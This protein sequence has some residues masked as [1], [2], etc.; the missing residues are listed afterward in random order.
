MIEQRGIVD[1]LVMFAVLVSAFLMGCLPMWNFD[2][3]MHIRT[4]QLILERQAIPYLDWYSFTDVDRPWI[5]M[6]WLFQ[7]GIA[8]LFELG[9]VRLL[10]LSKAL[11]QMITVVICWR[12][13]GNRLPTWSKAC[14]VLLLVVCLSGR[15]IVRPDM[16][17][18]FLL[19]LYL[20]IFVLAD[21]RPRLLLLLPI[22][23][24]IW[25]NCHGLF[26][27]G[28]VAVAAYCGDRVARY[29]AGDGRFYL[30]KLPVHSRLGW[31]VFAGLATLLAC[32]VNPYFE[33]GATFP[34]VLFSKLGNDPSE[35]HMSALQVFQ[36]TGFKTF[37]VAEMM[38]WC[39]AVVSFIWLASHRRVSL[40][41]L[42]LFIGFSYLAWM[43]ARN[44]AI[45]AIVATV[46]TCQNLSEVLKIREGHAPFI[47][48]RLAKCLPGTVLLITMLLMTSVVT[49][50]WHRFTGRDEFGIGELDDWY[51]HKAAEFAG[52]PGMP[53]RAFIYGYGQAAVFIFHNGPERRVFMDGRLEMYRDETID[54]YFRIVADIDRRHPGFIDPLLDDEGNLPTVIVGN[55]INKRKTLAALLTCP[56]IRLVYADSTAAVFVQVSVADKLQMPVA[57]PE[58]LRVNFQSAPGYF[59]GD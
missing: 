20:L 46:V 11:L 24:V 59:T 14:I 29:L 9:G 16:V 5:A 49:G 36:M 42:L 2:I 56:V 7:V 30:E 1:K 23:Q 26:V 15:S 6:H 28:V 4:G 3:W 37:L 54:R 53:S 50:S 12:A 41:R 38:L 58:P 48:L 55:T 34:L 13:A 57:N 44:I 43:A 52:Q 17:T 8:K 10:V 35:E 19:A 51:I 22:V 18:H 33:Q 32:L 21:E 31:I 39:G 40:M 25:T 47:D 27:L 45:F